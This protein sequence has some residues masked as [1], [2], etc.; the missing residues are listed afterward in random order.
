MLSL[1]LR[2]CLS[3]ASLAS[4]VVGDGLVQT[5]FV[6]VGPEGVAEVQLRVGYLPEQVVAYALLAAG[7]YEQVGVG[8]E[9]RR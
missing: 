1:H 6:E 7:A 8:H 3:E 9:A 5:F 2:L 4:L